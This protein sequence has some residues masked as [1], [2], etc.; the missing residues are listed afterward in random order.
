MPPHPQCQGTSEGNAYGI[1]G[2]EGRSKPWAKAVLSMPSGQGASAAP[3]GY[4]WKLHHVV[5][6][7]HQVL[8]ALT[9][10]AQPQGKNPNTKI[11][12]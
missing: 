1:L 8:Q 5:L 3:G 2:L 10:V 6:K 12:P 9:S 4:W 11:N 7:L